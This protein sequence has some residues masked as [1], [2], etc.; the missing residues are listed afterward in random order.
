MKQKLAITDLTRMQA[1]RVCFAGYSEDKKCIRPVLPPPGIKESSL[2]K[3]GYPIIYPFAI[4]ELDLLEADSQPPHTEDFIYNKN[5]P[6]LIR[7]VKDR[8]KLLQWSLFNGIQ[9]IFEQEV[10]DDFGF[11]VKDCQGTRSL[12]T[13]QPRGIHEVSYW[14]GEDGARG[15]RL[16]FYDHEG[17]YFNLKIVDLTWNYYCQSI[18][19][20]ETEPKEIAHKMTTL[21]KGN[22]IYL[23]IGLSRGWAKF[24]DRCYLQITGIYTFPDY[25][26]GRNFSHFANKIN[27]EHASG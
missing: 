13:I 2:Y 1:G 14:E 23:R 6:V 11:Y 20:Q 17:G 24:P 25:L 7:M 3:D 5:S 26:E 18:R 21:L 15:Y 8:E 10:F 12:G 19:D 27:P 16:K 9:T 4:I 22:K